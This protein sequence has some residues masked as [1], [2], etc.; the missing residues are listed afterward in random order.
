MRR[1]CQNHGAIE[2]THFSEMP[3]AERPYKVKV[4]LC[5]DCADRVETIGFPVQPLAAHQ[6]KP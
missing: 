6:E 1:W 3:S 2:A 5:T 4:P